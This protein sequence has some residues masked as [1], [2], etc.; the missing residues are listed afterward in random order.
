[1]SNFDHIAFAARTDVGKKRKNNEDAFGTFPDAGIFCVADGM[2]G[3]DDGEIASAAVIKGVEDVAK[4]CAPPAEGGYAAADVAEVLETGLCKASEWMFN[5]AAEKRLSGCGS[6][7]VGIVLDA[8]RP[9]SALAVHAGDSRLYLLHGKSIRQITRDHSA[10][11]MMGA[12]DESKI[13]PMFRSMV[14]NAV[15]IKPKVE[16][17]TTPFKVSSGDRVLI[18]SDGL[19]RM[20]PDKKIA[21]I[22]RGHE[23][24]GEAADALIAAALEAGGIDNVT[25]VLVEFGQLP[26][27]VGAQQLPDPAAGFVNDEKETSDPTEST[28]APTDAPDYETEGES[29]TMQTMQPTVSRTNFSATRRFAVSKAYTGP[30]SRHPRLVVVVCAAVVAALSAGALWVIMGRRGSVPPTAPETAA[31]A[32]QP[33]SKADGAVTVDKVTPDDGGMHP[34]DPPLPEKA[35]ETVGDKEKQDDLDL[36]RTVP[37]GRAEEHPASPEA[38]QL[39]PESAKT[40]EMTDSRQTESVGRGE[41]RTNSANGESAVGAP[42]VGISAAEAM[43]D[44][45]DAADVGKILATIRRLFPGGK[46][47]FEYLEQS[48]NFEKSARVCARMRSAKAAGNAAVD[49]KIMLAAAKDA[50]DALK[51][52]ADMSESERKWLMEWD[53]IA[54]GDPKDEEMQ[55]SCA[56]FIL[57]AEEVRTR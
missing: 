38:E 2:G 21:S 35:K 33:P 45:C 55:R 22:S 29:Q 25:V 46:P 1:M 41:S 34:N 47:T 39:R 49:M 6:T 56:R 11:E 20:V 17:E 13:N 32:V 10:A 16:V 44:A 24:V 43:A 5:R 53:K 26:E 4:L 36:S 3:G 57:S 12:K 23:D 8:T 28:D 19:S 27:P 7:F 40:P 30:D 18:C 37:G 14:M 51:A 15:G 52:S 54:G 31:S 48:R 50:R 42:I 9:D